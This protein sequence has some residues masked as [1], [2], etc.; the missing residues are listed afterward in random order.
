[1]HKAFAIIIIICLL[2]HAASSNLRKEKKESMVIYVTPTEV[3]R[4][5]LQLVGLDESRQNTYILLIAY[6]VATCLKGGV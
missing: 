4:R 5:G 6:T 3:L 2:S 1:M